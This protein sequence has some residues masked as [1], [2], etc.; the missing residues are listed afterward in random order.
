M[1][2]VALGVAWALG[3]LTISLVGLALAAELAT[4]GVGTITPSTNVI[5]D[6]YKDVSFVPGRASCTMEKTRM[7]SIN[8]TC[9]MNTIKLRSVLEQQTCHSSEATIPTYRCMVE[10]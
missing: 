1:L 8:M 9:T 4:V 3:E 5:M 10:M 2:V 6:Q 7:V